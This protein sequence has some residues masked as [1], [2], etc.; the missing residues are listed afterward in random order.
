MNTNIEYM[1]AA[2]FAIVIV[3]LISVIVTEIGAAYG[4]HLEKENQR[5]AEE[6]RAKR[7]K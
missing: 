5:R 7:R 2:I 3:C 1:I 6:I 4:R